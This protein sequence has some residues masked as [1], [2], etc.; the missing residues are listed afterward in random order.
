MRSRFRAGVIATAAIVACKFAPIPATG[1]GAVD[2]P[3]LPDAGPCSG[4]TT[5][6]AN[7]DTLR[8][9]LGSGTTAVDTACAWGCLGSSAHCG[10]LVPAGGGVLPADLDPD[11]QLGDITLVGTIDGGNGAIS[12]L[13]P[14]GSEGQIVN[15]IGYTVRNDIAIFR[16]KSIHVTGNQ[17]ALG[18]P[19]PIALVATGD[20]VIDDAVDV[21]GG[22][23]GSNAGPGGFAGGPTTGGEAAGSGGGQGGGNDAAASAGGGGY[24][25]SGGS[26]LVLPTSTSAPAHGGTPFG[27]DKI[28]L[29]IGG[30]GGG[31]GGHG[32]APV[33]GGGGGAVQLVANGTITISTNASINAGGCGGTHG[34]NGDWA[35]GE[36]P[37]GRS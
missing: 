37:A 4:I 5:E 33:G 15:G 18:G 25:G 19:Y 23:S 28:T 16:F 14:S 30:G 2:G 1:D 29:L 13:R 17:L 21:Q 34:A 26:G 11:P 35:P 31:A 7:A 9:C 24:G 12:S 22:C 27:D 3:I 8:T 32:G 36:V 20:I 6:C 10:K